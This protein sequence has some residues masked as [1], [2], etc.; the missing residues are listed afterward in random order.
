MY[1]FTCKTNVYWNVA[2]VT[3]SQSIDFPDVYRFIHLFTLLLHRLSQVHKNRSTTKP[4]SN[5]KKFCHSI[6]TVQEIRYI[7]ISVLIEKK[8]SSTPLIVLWS[9]FL[10][11][12]STIVLTNFFVLFGWWWFMISLTAI[13]SLSW[14]DFGE[15]NRYL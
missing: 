5:S 9:S 1:V 10:S 7:I 2:H 3:Y 6:I 13:F 15:M 12:P 14:R 8:I 11:S 4:Q